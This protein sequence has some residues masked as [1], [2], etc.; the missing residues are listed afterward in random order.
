MCV[1]QTRTLPYDQDL[2]SR[3][4]HISDGKSNRLHTCRL[5]CSTSKGQAF[6]KRSLGAAPRRRS[7]N[8]MYDYRLLPFCA[9]ASEQGIDPH[10]QSSSLFPLSNLADP[11]PQMHNGYWSCLASVLS[12][13]G[14]G[15]GVHDRI[16]LGMI[17]FMK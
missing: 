10:S 5:S 16:I 1:N 6:Q 11:R 2:W 4:D 14:K 3:P 8:H 9:W 15:Q 17:S 13:S 12:C 7:T